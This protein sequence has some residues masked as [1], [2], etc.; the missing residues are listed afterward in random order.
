[1]RNPRLAFRYAKSLIDLAVEKDQLEQ[2]FTDMKW[3]NGVTKSNKDVVSLLRSPVIKP[4][5][6]KKILEAITKNNI[7]EMTAG[8][9]RLLVTKG[10]ESDLPEI[11]TA[12]IT[13]YKEKKNIRTVKLTTATPLS[14]DIKNVIINQVKTSAGFE[15]VEIL[16]EVDE[17]LIGGF[18]LQVED[19]LIDA[20]VIYDLRNIAKQF[21]NNDFIYKV[22]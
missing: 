15:K 3:L 10:R 18:V 22:R 12:F 13:A 21:E 9:I 2:V 14:D 4:D 19:K 8:F 6:K 7:S 1:M 11:S 17:S 16:E 20:S 5:T